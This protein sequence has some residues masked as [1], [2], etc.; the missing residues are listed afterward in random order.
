M[1]KFNF[2][3]QTSISDIPAHMR[4]QDILKEINASSEYQL[5]RL[6]FINYCRRIPPPL[7]AKRVGG[8]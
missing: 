7:S 1:A 8:G 2:V 6:V 5:E 4:L 3:I